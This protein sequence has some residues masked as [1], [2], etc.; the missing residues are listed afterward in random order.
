MIHSSI[1]CQI[2][3]LCTITGRLQVGIIKPSLKKPGEDEQCLFPGY[4]KGINRR[5][6]TAL[7]SNSDSSIA[8]IWSQI[9]ARGSRRTQIVT[10]RLW[11][12]NPLVDYNPH[13]GKLCIN[14]S[15]MV[16]GKGGE[17]LKIATDI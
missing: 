9:G 5:H 14:I 10:Q 7:V 16:I 2:S 1:L 3:E 13:F 15:Y 11:A 6:P 4:H 12:H 8:P 17:I